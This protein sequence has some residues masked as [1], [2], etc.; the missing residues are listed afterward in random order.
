MQ[1]FAYSAL[2]KIEKEQTELKKKKKKSPFKI[3]IFFKSLSCWVPGPLPRRRQG[4]VRWTE[5][6][7]LFISSPNSSQ[8][9]PSY[10]E[11][12]KVTF[13]GLYALKYFL[14]GQSGFQ[15]WSSHLTEEAAL[16]HGAWALWTLPNPLLPWKPA[17]PF[18]SAED[19]ISMWEFT[20]WFPCKGLGGQLKPRIYPLN[21]GF[22]ELLRQTKHK[23]YRLLSTHMETGPL[24]FL[25]FSLSLSH[26]P[27]G[28]LLGERLICFLTFSGWGSTSNPTTTTRQPSAPPS[29]KSCLP[30]PAWHLPSHPAAAWCH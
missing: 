23:L 13:V 7:S 10:L 1:S 14:R 29:R 16:W 11:L 22:Q 27:N 2:L 25:S 4:E 6:M 30:C 18:G 8:L 26:F 15:L 9:L 20:L 21:L 28:T 3:I 12:D 5:E 19:V 24:W 17:T